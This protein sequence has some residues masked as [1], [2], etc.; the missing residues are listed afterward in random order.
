MSTA[1]GRWA[2]ATDTGVGRA[3]AMLDLLPPSETGHGLAVP[4]P[5][6]DRTGYQAGRD[7]KQINAAIERAP[8]VTVPLAGLYAIQH[9][10]RESKVLYHLEHP[11]S[12]GALHPDAGTP[13]DRPIVVQAGGVRYIHDGHHRLSADKLRGMQSAKVRLVDLDKEQT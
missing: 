7:N 5:F 6:K 3:R 9:S 13:V 12:P 8:I 1:V 11:R 2:A 10:I 4:F